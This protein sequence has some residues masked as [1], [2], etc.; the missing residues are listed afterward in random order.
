MKVT[1]ERVVFDKKPVFFNLMQ[2]YLYD[3][4]EYDGWDISEQGYF[5]YG[6]IDHYWTEQGR[7]PFFIRV[8]G[9]L[10]GLAM[11]R[12]V[13]G[14]TSAQDYYSMAE[15]FVMRKFRG[16]GVAKAAATMLL[17]MFAGNW[18][19]GQTSGNKQA[20]AFWRK[21]IAEY[22]NGAFSEEELPDEDF[23]WLKGPVQKFTSQGKTLVYLVRHA[24]SKYTPDELGRPITEKGQR[25]ALQVARSLSYEQLDA[26]YS[27]PYRRAI[28]TVEP[29]AN[30]NSKAVELIE[31]FR[32]RSL[33]AGEVDFDEAA[34]KTWKD[35]AFSYP[36]GES[37]FQAQA[38]GV[39]SLEGLLQ[40]N[41][42]KRIAIGTHGTLMSLILNYYDPK[43]FDYEFWRQLDMPDIYLLVFTGTDQWSTRIWQRRG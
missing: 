36:G 1:I 19:V 3:S 5:R 31:D 27:S 40:S 21:L 29:L 24:E 20:Q 33:V 25:D 32:E 6:Y 28:Q 35:F 42:G 4:S 9:K 2:L 12:T 38:R 10:A 41:L 39:A 34:L 15:F 37:N 22:T 13:F 23:P 18:H 7:H 17:D 43:R 8:D 11:I 14:D 30:Q 26:I 16:R